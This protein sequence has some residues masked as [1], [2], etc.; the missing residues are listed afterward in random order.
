MPPRE[1]RVNISSP[2]PSLGSLDQ[3]CTICLSPIYNTER[4]LMER[5]THSFHREC[6]HNWHRTERRNGRPLSCPICR[7]IGPAAIDI[8]PVFKL[9][10]GLFGP[11]GQVELHPDHIIVRTKYILS[12][13]NKQAIY[14]INIGGFFRSGKCVILVDRQH[15]VL[16]TFYVRKCDEFF[17][18]LGKVTTKFYDETGRRLSIARPHFLET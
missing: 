18:E 16:S 15:E 2:T 5:C 11:W 10:G 7:T 14:L 8:T 4:V 3:E 17:K 12:H 1:I 9:L 6:I 13:M